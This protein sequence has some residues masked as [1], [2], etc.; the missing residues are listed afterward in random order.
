[1]DRL[2][3]IWLTTEIEPHRHE[4]QCCYEEEGDSLQ[5][6]QSLLASYKEVIRNFKEPPSLPEAY[7]CHP[8]VTQLPFHPCFVI[9]SHTS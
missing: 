7:K 2:N 8:N 1:M 6:P 3:A 4:L 9:L 5:C